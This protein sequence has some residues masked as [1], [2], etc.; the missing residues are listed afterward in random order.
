MTL[1][2]E[3]GGDVNC[4][5][6]EDSNM[7]ERYLTERLSLAELEAFEQHYLECRRCFDELQLRHAATIELAHAGPTPRTASRGVSYWRWSA[8]AAALVL[9][10][11][12]TVNYLRPVST[13]SATTPPASTGPDPAALPQLAMVDLPPYAPTQARGGEA[14]RSRQLFEAGMIAYMQGNCGKAIESLSQ[15][16]Q[17]DSEND[18]ATF[19]LGVCYLNVMRQEDAISQLSRLTASLNAYSEES[20]W[21]LA[22]AYLQKKDASRAKAELEN[23]ASMNKAYAPD[24]TGLLKRIRDLGFQ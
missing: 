16:T 20:H 19:Y 13:P 10:A 6:V 21:Y 23:V 18:P 12:L 8:V 1:R 22:M 24:A 2:D 3:R 14:T 7:I 5:Q 9:V 4:Q 11:F 15:A 17:L